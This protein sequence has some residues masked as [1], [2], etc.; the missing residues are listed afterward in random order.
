MNLK[1]SKAWHNTWYTEE[2]YTNDV[3]SE[4]TIISFNTQNNY[5]LYIP[6]FTLRITVIEKVP[7]LNWS[8]GTAPTF[9]VWL[10][11]EEETHISLWNFSFTEQWISSF[12]LKSQSLWIF[13]ETRKKRKK[14]SNSDFFLPS[15]YSY[16]GKYPW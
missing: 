10:E 5:V 13:L 15:K 7:P 8:P 2:Y 14:I 16:L 9:L 6:D 12:V 1:I 11:S 3:F 4:R